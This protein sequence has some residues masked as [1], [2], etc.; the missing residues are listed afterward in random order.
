MATKDL[1]II[2][3]DVEEDYDA[4]K[5][6]NDLNSK[7]LVAIKKY[8]QYGSKNKGNMILRVK[9]VTSK[10]NICNIGK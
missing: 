6:Q 2:I 4:R 10:D 1:K 8:K 7:D 9:N 3:R 5:E